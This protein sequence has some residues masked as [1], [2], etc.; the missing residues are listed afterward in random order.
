MRTIVCG[1][2][3]II[4]V[5]IDLLV[6]VLF[7]PLCL[8]HDMCASLQACCD[9]KVSGNEIIHICVKRHQL[10]A[11][12]PCGQKEKLT[13]HIPKVSVAKIGAKRLPLCL[14]FF[15]SRVV[16][17]VTR[18]SHEQ[19]TKMSPV[20]VGGGVVRLVGC[21]QVRERTTHSRTPQQQ[22]INQSQ[23]S[24]VIIILQEHQNETT[25]LCA[26]WHECVLF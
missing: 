25:V 9:Q 24:S 11:L 16:T 22:S 15:K 23:S 14:K 4:L 17:W 7:V 19:T 8:R 26:A 5:C 20:F 2:D 13:F 12:A 6:V 18:K 1:D 21:T 10:V 3:A